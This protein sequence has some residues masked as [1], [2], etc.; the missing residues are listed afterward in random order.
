MK[1]NEW[2]W[3]K[4]SEAFDVDKGGKDENEKLGEKKLTH[5]HVEQ[6]RQ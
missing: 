3:V 5:S 2:S 4:L 1:E 6:Q